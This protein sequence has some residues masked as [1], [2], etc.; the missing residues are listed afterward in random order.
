MA[1]HLQAAPEALLLLALPFPLCRRRRLTV[2][3]APPCRRQMEA[4]WALPL[5]SIQLAPV[6]HL[7][8]QM[9]VL[10]HALQVSSVR[11][12]MPKAVCLPAGSAEK[13]ILDAPI[14]SITTLVPPVGI[15]LQS[16]VLARLVMREKPIHRSSD[17]DIKIELCRRIEP[18][19]APRP[20]NSLRQRALRKETTVLLQATP[21]I[22]RAHV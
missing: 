20:F 7:H 13:T 9:E 19:L 17:S 10:S 12:R 1:K 6:A 2:G 11:L 21:Q 3:L 15:G 14:T 8:R 22:G 4:A 5:R 18:A 16:T